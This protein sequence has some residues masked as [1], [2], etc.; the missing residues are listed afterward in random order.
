MSAEHEQMKLPAGKTCDSCFAFYFCNGIG[1]TWPGRTECDYFPNR[2]HEET[3]Q[4]P[5][6][7]Q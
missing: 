3:P 2:F 4:Q 5:K 1:C 6:D 7:G